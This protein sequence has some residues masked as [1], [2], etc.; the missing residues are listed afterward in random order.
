MRG[1]AKNKSVQENRAS[2][3]GVS[4]IED[5][6]RDFVIG[7][8]MLRKSPGFSIVAILTLALGIGVNT[9]IF[10]LVN[11]LLLRPL[12]FK[13]PQ[14]L[15]WISNIFEGGLSGE[16]T[17]VGNFREWRAENKSFEDLSAYFAFFD[18]A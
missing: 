9:S 8:R 3:R 2:E 7:A 6:W 10:S 1:V 11:A 16:T 15:V 5:A 12:P 17:T 13:D 18:Y 14:R 4:W